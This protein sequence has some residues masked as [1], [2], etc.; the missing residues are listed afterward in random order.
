MEPLLAVSL[1]SPIVSKT[2]KN[3]SDIRTRLLFHEPRLPGQQIQQHQFPEVQV[4]TT[5]L[6]GESTRHAVSQIQRTSLLRT[7]R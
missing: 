7:T 1:C 3:V 2:Y 5:G 4:P 6:W